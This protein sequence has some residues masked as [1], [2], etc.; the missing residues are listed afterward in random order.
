MTVNAR[1]VARRQGVTALPSGRAV[2][3]LVAQHQIRC[4]SR[5]SRA[6]TAS[7]PSR[8]MTLMPLALTRSFTRR[9]SDG[10]K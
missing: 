8:S 7:M 5:R 6:M 1:S 10:R 3:D 2:A 9:P 4:P